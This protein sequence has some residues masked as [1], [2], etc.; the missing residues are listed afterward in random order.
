MKT[1]D[2]LALLE[3][4]RGLWS[5]TTVCAEMA[6]SLKGLAQRECFDPAEQARLALAGGLV[7]LL[8]RLADEAQGSL[9][10]DLTR[11]AA[12]QAREPPP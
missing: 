9:L 5:V 4:D 11:R 8:S 7:A 2:A 10:A 12:E 3:L 1:D 6:G